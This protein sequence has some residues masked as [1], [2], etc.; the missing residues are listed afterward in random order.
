MLTVRV[1]KKPAGKR[2]NEFEK[3]YEASAAAFRFFWKF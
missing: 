3:V 2:I 1:H